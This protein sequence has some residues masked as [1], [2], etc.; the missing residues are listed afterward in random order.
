MFPKNSVLMEL[1]RHLAMKLE[2]RGTQGKLIT[3]YSSQF[4]QNCAEAKDASPDPIDFELSWIVFLVLV[5]GMILAI[6]V[7]IVEKIT[8]KNELKGRAQ[9]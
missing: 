7:A 8:Y 4:N 2:E 9:Y 5:A 6:L 1:F 3:R